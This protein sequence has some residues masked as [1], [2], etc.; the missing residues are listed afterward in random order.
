MKIEIGSI[1]SPPASISS[2]VA[3]NGS[4]GISMRAE[5]YEP[6]AHMI[7]EQTHSADAPPL[8]AA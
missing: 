1:T 4:V 3:A 5:R 8:R 2:D 7:A 6:V